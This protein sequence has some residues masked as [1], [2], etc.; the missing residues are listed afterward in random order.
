MAFLEEISPANLYAFDPLIPEVLKKQAMD[1]VGLH[2]YGISESEEAA[3]VIVFQE[4]VNVAEIRYLYVV[5]YL[6]G[7]GVM[8]QAL[9]ELFLQ[10]RDNGYNYVR[11][12]YLPEE[13]RNFIP[14]SKRFG[15]K[16]DALDMAYF[17]FRAEDI[18]KCRATTFAPKGI[19]RLKYLPDDKKTQ[20][21]KIIDKNMTFYNYDLTEKSD[22]LP[23]SMAYL[24]NDQPKGALVVESPRVT[25]LPATDDKQRFP[26]PE[27]FDLV[28]F[29]VG[30][31]TMMA[32]MYLLSGL[33]KIIQTELN[34]N[35]VMTGY[36]PE[37]HVTR[38]LEGTLGI[39][40]YHEVCATLDLSLL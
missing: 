2:F 18:K 22:I 32:P 12:N 33:C 5:P 30:T 1:Q 20:L 37:G 39:K 36:F 6:R 13:F 10:L 29:F 14:I 7:T 3:G 26:D 21:F 25:L 40:G 23:Y 27:A 38:L 16:E 9:A 31:K 34:D 11:V 4:K 24:E 8:D 19:L 28:L 15:F 17:R 35:V